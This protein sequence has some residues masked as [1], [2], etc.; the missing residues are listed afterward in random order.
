MCEAGGKVKYQDVTESE[1]FIENILTNQL[2]LTF[3]SDT[4]VTK[5]KIIIML[6]LH[7]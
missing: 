1:N 7:L 3:L 5:S 4:A 6:F 2:N